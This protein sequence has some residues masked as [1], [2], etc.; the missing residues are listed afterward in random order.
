MKD[1]Y[2]SLSILLKYTGDEFKDTFWQAEHDEAF[3]SGPPPGNMNEKDALRLDELGFVY[4]ESIDSWHTF[5]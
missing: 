1:L 4:D 3:F 5:S 2:E